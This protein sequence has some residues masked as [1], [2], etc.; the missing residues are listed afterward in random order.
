M[1]KGGRTRLCEQAMLVA[2]RQRANECERNY[3]VTQKANEEG[4]KKLKGTE[5]KVRQLQDYI[6]RYY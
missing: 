2:E 4:R 3:V 6:N 5:R 1:T